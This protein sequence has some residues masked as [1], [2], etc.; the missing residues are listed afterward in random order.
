MIRPV[1]EVKAKFNP[2]HEKDPNELHQKIKHSYLSSRLFEFLNESV[3][4]P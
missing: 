1:F 2:N 4:N 3:S